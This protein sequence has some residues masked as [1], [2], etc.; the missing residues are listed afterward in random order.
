M[1][2][3]RRN[4]CNQNEQ[5]PT[6]LNCNVEKLSIFKLQVAGK[7][8]KFSNYSAEFML[9][10]NWFW[11]EIILQCYLENNSLVND[12]EATSMSLYICFKFNQN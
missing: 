3:T 11:H 2:N 4:S 8:A 6:I 10:V 9:T 7:Y 1:L 12:F 5:Q